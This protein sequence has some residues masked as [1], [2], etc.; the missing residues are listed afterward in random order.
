M[1]QHIRQGSSGPHISLL[2]A[3]LLYT[4]SISVA[5]TAQRRTRAGRL[6]R[7][8][9]LAITAT[10]LVPGESDRQRTPTVKY[11]PESSSEMD[12]IA[13]L[14]DPVFSFP[15]PTISQGNSLTRHLHHSVSHN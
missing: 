6:N 3:R 4:R 13:A 1:G 12:S 2:T 14:A 5:A 11:P 7:A 8:R 9:A 15:T 10:R